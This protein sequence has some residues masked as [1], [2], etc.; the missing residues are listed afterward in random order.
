MIDELPDH[1]FEGGFLLIVT[2]EKGR[3]SYEKNFINDNS[4][5]GSLYN[6]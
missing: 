6:Y 2:K 1:L 3:Q 4:S 5:S